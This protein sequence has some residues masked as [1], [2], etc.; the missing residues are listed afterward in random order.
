MYGS[1]AD[2]EGSIPFTR[3]DTK[4]PGQDSRL[5]LAFLISMALV[6]GLGPLGRLG[7]F[8][9]RLSCPSRGT[10]PGLLLFLLDSRA[11]GVGDCLIGLAAGVLVDQR[12]TRAVVPHPG[13][14]IAETGPGL[15]RQRVPGVPEVV[16]VQ[17][18][19]TDVLGSG[20]PLHQ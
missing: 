12:G 11:Q 19:H 9:W 8:C 4:T 18:A 6:M 14:E 10:L 1:Q 20:R 16:E 2:S 15:R 7:R 13:H 5:D 3:S 17:T